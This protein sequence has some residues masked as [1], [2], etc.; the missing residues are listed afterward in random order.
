MSYEIVETKIKEILIEVLKLKQAPE[1]ISSQT[2]FFSNS[3]VNPGLI[4][5]SLAILE[6]SSRLAE[7]F[8][9][10]PSEIEETAYQNIGT[11]TEA[12][13]SLKAA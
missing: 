6:I 8:D 10:I 2:P 11:L 12:I 9:L 4:E 3:P 5:D 13:S 7:E 1:S